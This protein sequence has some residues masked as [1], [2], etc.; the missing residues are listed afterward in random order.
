MELGLGGFIGIIVLASSRSA[1]VVSID[2]TAKAI[3]SESQTLHALLR[4]ATHDLHR[5]LDQHRVLLPLLSAVTT[6][7]QYQRALVALYAVLSPVETAIG[8]YIDAWGLALNYEARRRMPLLAQ[9]LQRY[10]LTPPDGAWAGPSIETVGE[11]IGSLYVLE[12]ATRGG[13]VIFRRMQ[14]VLGVTKDHGGQFFYGHGDQS[15]QQWQD[16]WRFAAATCPQKQ[17][18]AACRAATM[19]LTSVLNVL[20]EY[21]D[22]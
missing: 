7:A 13:A 15:D 3:P 16:F 5:R 4:G 12:G 11:L 10:G 19:L 18:P 2:V 14:R 22:R 8:G 17:W 6:Q 1:S 21:L 9:D 20:D